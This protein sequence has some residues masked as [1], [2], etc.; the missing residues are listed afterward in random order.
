MGNLAYQKDRIKGGDRQ[1]IDRREKG[2]IALQNIR[3]ID[4]SAVNCNF[5]NPP[6]ENIIIYINSVTGFN[7]DRKSLL[8]VGERINT[9]KRLINCKLG[10][11]RQDDKLPQH[12]M[13]IM[14]EGKTKG[15]KLDL[16]KNLQRY[17]KERGWD[18]N[19]G[20]P[21]QDTLNELGI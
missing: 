14:D 16:E 12:L 19:T 5:R 11:S 7:Y 1:S 4:D 6:L 3:A 8:K 10:I 17:Y 13:K 20:W 18:W 2:V 9:L 21:T 15:V